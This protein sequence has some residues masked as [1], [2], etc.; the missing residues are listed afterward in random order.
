LQP[1]IERWSDIVDFEVI[2]VVESGEYWRRAGAAGEAP[3]ERR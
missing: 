2:P 3:D 1:W